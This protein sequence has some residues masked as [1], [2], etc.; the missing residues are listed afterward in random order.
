MLKMHLKGNNC[1]SSLFKQPFG[2]KK[3]KQ[4]LRVL[5]MKEMLKWLNIGELQYNK[6]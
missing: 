4:D 3:I 1:R 5:K 2:R 6:I